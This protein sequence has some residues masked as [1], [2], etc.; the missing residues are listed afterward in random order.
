MLPH[1]SDD[2]DK[3]SLQMAGTGQLTICKC[4]KFNILNSGILCQ[5]LLKLL[6]CTFGSIGVIGGGIG[7][8]GDCR[9]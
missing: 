2:Y 7:I 9:W 8:G 1:G 3:F 5:A 6:C 4:P